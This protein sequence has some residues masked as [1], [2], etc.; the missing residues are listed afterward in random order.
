MDNLIKSENIETGLPQRTIKKRWYDERP[1]ATNVLGH[2][3]NLSIRSHYEISREVIRVVESIKQHNRELDEVPLSLGVDRVLGLYQEQNKRRWYDNSLPIS[4][5]FK[6]ASTL[7]DE[8]FHNI[9]QGIEISL[10]GE[11]VD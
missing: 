7:Q 11:E 1:F 6:T 8:D 9:M 2:L 10:V 5:V 3:K 4:R